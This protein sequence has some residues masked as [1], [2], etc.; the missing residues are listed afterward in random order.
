[1]KATSAKALKV[2]ATKGLMVV[3]GDSICLVGVGN[4]D[5]HDTVTVRG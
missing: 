3:T 1:M 5:V 4:R 2:E